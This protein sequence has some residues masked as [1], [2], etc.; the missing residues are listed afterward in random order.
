MVGTILGVLFGLLLLFLVGQA[1]WKP[2]RIILYMGLRLILGCVFLLLVNFTA[3]SLGLLGFSL[4]VNPASALTVGLLGLPG[5][6]L[7]I[8][9]KAVAG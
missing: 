8:A 4:G 2:L 1:L 7:L 6:L 5:L 9:L 3:G